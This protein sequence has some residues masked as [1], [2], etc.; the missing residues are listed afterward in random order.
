MA[1]QGNVAGVVEELMDVA[2][3]RPRCA[4]DPSMHRAIHVADEVE[5][6]HSE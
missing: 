2:K 3:L 4:E 5:Y 6:D 1:H